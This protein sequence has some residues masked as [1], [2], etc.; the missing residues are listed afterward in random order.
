MGFLD[1]AVSFRGITRGVVDAPQV[2]LRL[3]PDA[4][5]ADLLHSLGD[6]YGPRFQERVFAQDGSLQSYVTLV[7]NGATVEGSDL[8]HRLAA[9]GQEQVEAQVFIFSAMAGG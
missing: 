6:R 8:G 3:S 4:T 1:V 7:V 2:Q 9:E 5:V